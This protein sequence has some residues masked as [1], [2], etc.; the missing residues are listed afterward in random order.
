MQWNIAICLPSLPVSGVGTSVGYLEAGLKAAGCNVKMV[1]TGHDVG[2]D[3]EY[4]K[5]QGWMLELVGKGERF[6]P[7]RMLLVA[8]FLNSGGFD[9]VFN[10][11]SPETQL[12]LPCLKSHIIRVAVI[13]ALNPTALKHIG[14]N[15]AY[16]HTVIGISKEMTQAMASDPNIQAPVKLIPNCTI[17]KSESYP[18]LKPT[19]KICFV[20]RVSNPDKNV[21]ILPA[22][23]DHLKTRGISFSMDIVGDGPDRAL[24]EREFRKRKSSEVIFH[25]VLPR[26]ATNQI[27][28]N[29]NFVLLPSIYEGLSNVMLEGM[30][31][32]CVPICSDIANFRWVLGD[33]AGQLQCSI[34]QAD[35]YAQQIAKLSETPEHYRSIQKY[36]RNRQQELFSLESTVQSYLELFTGLKSGK[37]RQLPLPVDFKKIAIPREYRLY[38]SRLWRVAQVAKNIVTGRS[39][40][41]R[42]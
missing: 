16:L 42:K 34:H 6:L 19:L 12:I 21:S 39:K 23:V 10:N 1:T 9:I 22:I 14:M 28:K 38:C 33:V 25:G 37:G 20:G 40:N 36:L 18:E 15:S 24:L 30:A 5:R 11:T 13:R 27:M 31:L 26:E 2:D 29:A 17:V 8:D 4:A 41:K 35:V 7:R 32:G 3:L